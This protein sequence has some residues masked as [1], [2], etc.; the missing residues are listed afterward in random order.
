MTRRLSTSA[1]QWLAPVSLLLPSLACDR[2][3]YVSTWSGFAY[4]A[5]VA[6]AYAPRILPAGGGNDG[7]V[8]CP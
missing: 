5:F 2:G 7:D 6:D 1:L 4:V 3:A 8:D